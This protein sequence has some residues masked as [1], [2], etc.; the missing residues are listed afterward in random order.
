MTLVLRVGVDPELEAE[1]DLLI[2]DSLQ[3]VFSQA[4]KSDI[5]TPWKMKMRLDREVYTANGTPDGSII[6]GMFHRAYNET[7]PYLNGC[8]GV[9]RRR[10]PGT[11]QYGAYLVEIG[12]DYVGHAGNG[13]WG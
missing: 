5:L 2:R 10:K 3:G 7:H 13:R 6:R 11:S 12:R 8:D 9:S 4:E 1:A